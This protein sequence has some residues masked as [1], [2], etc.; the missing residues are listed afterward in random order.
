[1]TTLNR[2]K[3]NFLSQRTWPFSSDDVLGCG[4]LGSH[5]VRR[6]FSK[7]TSDVAGL[8]RRK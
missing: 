1:M 8:T 3:Q 6:E 2:H 5:L 7:A 4:P